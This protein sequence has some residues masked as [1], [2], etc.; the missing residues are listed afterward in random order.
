MSTKS[1][2]LE[3]HEAMASLLDAKIGH[4]AEW[5]AFR[6]VNRALLAAKAQEAQV[7]SEQPGMR[8]RNL[9][10]ASDEP[11]AVLHKSN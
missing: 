10:A 3:A 6:A 5:K 4:M 1:D 7:T 8:I 11:T 2:L 9:A